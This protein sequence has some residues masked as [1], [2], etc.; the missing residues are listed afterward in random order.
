MESDTSMGQQR[1]LEQ[2]YSIQRSLTERNEL[3]CQV[4]QERE[5]LRHL[6]L[7]VQS[8]SGT[9][10]SES[11]SICNRS[12]ER[13]VV[14]TSPEL[15]VRASEFVLAVPVY[16]SARMTPAVSVMHSFT[17]VPGVPVCSPQQVQNNQSVVHTNLFQ[18]PVNPGIGSAGGMLDTRDSADC[19]TVSMS[20]PSTDNNLEMMPK[21]DGFEKG[22]HARFC[23]VKQD[24]RHAITIFSK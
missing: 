3:L 22:L 13:E 19:C 17:G 4:V 8:Q 15:P 6:L 24:R 1:M 21:Y 16:P 7:T 5:Q 10:Q 23:M 14:Y 18:M 9:G 12:S 20:R 11:S 2:L